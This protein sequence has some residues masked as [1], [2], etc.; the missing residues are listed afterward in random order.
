MLLSEGA[1]PSVGPHNCCYLLAPADQL[2]GPNAFPNNYYI[3]FTV[4]PPRRIRQHNGEIKGGAKHTKSLAPWEMLCV[5]HGFPSQTAA[6][7]FE[8]AWQHCRRSLRLRP[9][10]AEFTKWVTRQ[11]RTI[12]KAFPDAQGVGITSLFAKFAVLHKMLAIAP[13]VHFQIHIRYIHPVCKEFLDRYC[14]DVL[15]DLSNKSLTVSWGHFDS[16]TVT[17]FARD[18]VSPASSADNESCAGEKAC[19]ICFSAGRPDAYFGHCPSCRAAAHLV[20][21]W[22]NNA[23]PGRILPRDVTCPTCGTLL[24]WSSVIAN[25]GRGSERQAT[26]IS[27]LVDPMMAMSLSTIPD[28]IDLRSSDDE[29]SNGSETQRPRTSSPVTQP[30]A[31]PSQLLGN[32]GDDEQQVADPPPSIRQPVSP[33]RLLST[34]LLDRLAAKRQ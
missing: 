10:W 26:S 34:S 3:G 25:S 16:S 8:W 11:G 17:M 15:A 30:P 6:L 7:Q 9:V 32:D 4:N 31:G 19:H 29:D 27:S 12:R 14:G 28:V 1:F 18:D 24:P 5:V 2:A 33:S 21:L 13:W 20:C 23:E 22:R